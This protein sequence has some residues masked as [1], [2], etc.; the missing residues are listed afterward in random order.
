MYWISDNFSSE[1]A[2][3]YDNCRARYKLSPC[4]IE[5]NHL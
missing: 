2:T 5:T 4:N 1:F 3:G